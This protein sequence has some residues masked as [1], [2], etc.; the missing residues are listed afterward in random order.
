MNYDAD[1]IR[2]LD[3]VNTFNIFYTP[4]WF[5]APEAANAPANDLQFLRSMESFKEI[6]SEMAENVLKTWYRHV[7][8]LIP[9]YACLSLV[10]SIVSDQEKKLI[11]NEMLKHEP[12]TEYS[13]D[14]PSL[15]KPAVEL[16]AKTELHQLA[17]GPRVY[18]IFHLIGIQDP[19]PFLKKEPREWELDPDFQKLREFVSNLKVVNDCAERAVQL[20]TDFNEKIT[21][22]PDQM[23]YLYSTVNQ[24]RRDRSD[25]RREV[26]QPG[27]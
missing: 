17:K 18:L 3:R 25:L 20:A 26:L 10:S 21:K 5:S 6:D 23:T 12:P 9:E 19:R 13:I 22:N 4:Y 8:F 7:D 16:T 27:Q 14:K 24:Q 15:S 11:A 2:K 1:Y